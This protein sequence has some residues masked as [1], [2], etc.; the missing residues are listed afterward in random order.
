MCRRYGCSER[1]LTLPHQGAHPGTVHTD[2]YV[3]SA[4]VG[5]RGRGGGRSPVLPHLGASLGSST[6]PVRL[7]W[8]GNVSR[9]INTQINP[10]NIEY[11]LPSDTYNSFARTIGAS[12]PKS[13]GI[14]PPGV[15]DHLRVQSHTPL[16]HPGIISDP[17]DFREGHKRVHILG[18]IQIIAHIRLF[19][20]CMKKHGKNT[21]VLMRLTLKRHTRP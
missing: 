7:G 4:Q 6:R 10:L 8:D 14:R 3:T 16:E 9:G 13:G 17:M 2:V 19:R 18:E 15:T 11:G 21:L 12:Q 20:M 1:L 5:I